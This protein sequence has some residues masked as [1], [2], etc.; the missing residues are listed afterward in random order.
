MSYVLSHWQAAWAFLVAG[1]LA[2]AVHAAG[3]RRLSAGPASGGHPGRE[4]AAFYG[5]LAAAVLAVASP[6]GYFSGVYL[7]V[8]A[9]QD[10]LLAVV[11]PSL[12]VLGAPW[13]A[14]SAGLAL[15][16]RRPRRATGQGVA[17]GGAAAAPAG[18]LPA[19]RPRTRWWLAWPAAAVLAF[20]VIWLGWH[21][22]VLYDA[23]LTST[24]VRYAEYVTYLAAG[25]WF[26]LQLIGSRPFSPVA[27]PLRRLGYLVATAAADTIL[28]MVGVFGSGLLYPGYAGRAHH[29]LTVIADQQVAG[30]VLWMGILPV[31][32]IASVALLSTWLD[33]EDRDDPSRELHRL[34]AAQAAGWPS[35]GGPGLAGW[36]SRPRY[37]R[38]TA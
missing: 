11:A 25:T 30:A 27:S 17:Q 38:P 6:I 14:L 24:V 3:L 21:L 5:G 31:L 4:A 26:W 7:W 1:A 13:L 19:G 34:T 35:R 18:R 20:N 15:L 12:I 33:H 2:A 36:P 10:L 9:L 8:R 29:V 28:G 16:V 22:P 32:I 37:R 23:A